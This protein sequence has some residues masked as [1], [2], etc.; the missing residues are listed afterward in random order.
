VATQLEQLL[1][2]LDRPGVTELTLAV[3]S[4]ITISTVKGVMN[5]TARPLG[6][7]Q[8]ANI[9]RG[10]ALEALLADES[11][12]A[13]PVGLK[14]GARAVMISVERGENPT[15]RLQPNRDATK[16]PRTATRARTNPPVDTLMDGPEPGEAPALELPSMHAAT[17]E[18]SMP[19]LAMPAAVP[20]VP[21]AK[22]AASPQDPQGG[23]PELDA[24]PEL[25]PDPEPEPTPP[26]DEDGIELGPPAMDNGPP[27]LELALDSGPSKAFDID[28]PPPRESRPSANRLRINVSVPPPVADESPG[29]IPA[30]RHKSVPLAPNARS[31]EALGLP[32]DIATT[33][34]RQ[35]SLVLITAPEGHGK[36]S[37][38]AALF[39]LI[40]RTWIQNVITI[41]E[42][43]DRESFDL[44]LTAAESGY[45]VLA[46]LA[47]AT[48]R[49]AIDSLLDHYP[50]MAHGRVKTRMLGALNAVIAK[51][52]P[53]TPTDVITGSTL[54]ALLGD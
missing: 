35:R 9:V 31:L 3:G 6:S 19:E 24:I 36:T 40:D 17:P 43:R 8:L 29:I 54:R 39:D 14:L 50:G 49:A 33:V 18:P 23:P 10:T 37:T 2:Q 30:Q 46:T 51:R 13:E 48:P 12:P 4:P 22:P 52:L 11:A 41:D 15:L 28:L 38:L 21:P 20:N 5:V 34:A 45:L 16:R 47:A 27:G 42:L 7:D 1:A 32:S 53:P 25:E 26:H 44:A